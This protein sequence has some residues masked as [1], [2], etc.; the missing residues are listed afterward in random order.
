[1][2]EVSLSQDSS[3]DSSSVSQGPKEES[4]ETHD[5]LA[6]RDDR[7][8][9]RQDLSENSSDE[10]SSAV[11]QR[12]LNRVAD[13]ISTRGGSSG[14]SSEEEPEIIS[15]DTIIE[16]LE[17][18]VLIK[19]VLGP[20]SRGE[21]PQMDRPSRTF[22][23][24]THCRMLTS[25]ILVADFCHDL[26]TSKRTTSTREVYYH[27]VTHF[28][29]KSECDKA[30]WDLAGAIRVPRYALGLTA[31]PKGWTCGC[32]ELYD[33]AGNLMWNG[34]SLPIH[35]MAVTMN[36]MEATTVQSD[37]RCILVV[38]KEGVYTRLSEDKFF[39]QYPCILVCGK[40]N[41]DIATR[42][43]V[44]FLSLELDLPVYGICDCNPY[45]ISV[46]HTYHYDEKAGGS[47]PGAKKTVHL[48]WLGLRPSQ[49]DELSLPPNVFQQQTEFDESRLASL[50]NENHAWNQQGNSE[51][52]VEELEEMQS[53]GRKVELE[54]LNWL[55]MDYMCSW[56]KSIL[57]QHDIEV[58]NGNGRSSEFII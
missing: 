41:P 23:H 25:V 39:Q 35:G 50:L 18:L 44:Q 58:A 51:M 52:R 21:V 53:S 26:L 34:R 1:M 45:G 22:L 12:L 46:L 31:S 4:Q 56:V 43:W 42:Q 13:D 38:E 30:I 32:L 14:S 16:R 48:Q 49:L 20:L 17:E 27:F 47:R 9:N 24:N 55:G 37:A 2:K 8:R 57:E 40:G 6:G 36:L 19:M 11:P 10:S 29:N 33:P 7:K 5:R 3:D 28:R 54:A 15:T